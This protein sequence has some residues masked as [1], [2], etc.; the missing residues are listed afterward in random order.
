MDFNIFSS[1]SEKE[2]PFE[3]VKL[4]FL[5]FKSCLIVIFMILGILSHCRAAQYK[6][7]NVVIIYV[8][9][10]FVLFGM[11][12]YD[13]FSS[14]L[15]IYYLL[16]LNLFGQVYML[17]IFLRELQPVTHSLVFRN[18]LKLVAVMLFY[19]FV[20]LVLAV[21]WGSS[22]HSKCQPERPYPWAFFFVMGGNIVVW[23]YHSLLRSNGYWI[24]QSFIEA[25]SDQPLMP[26]EPSNQLNQT[27]DEASETSALQ[28]DVAPALTTTS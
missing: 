3:V 19:V 17:G 20:V 25:T 24:D 6:M 4:C 23:L 26:E 11:L 14:M 22:V 18:M 28:T 2:D 1:D 7:S 5:V 12:V 13:F 9:Y 27:L 10:I 21:G 15:L 8:F 16:I